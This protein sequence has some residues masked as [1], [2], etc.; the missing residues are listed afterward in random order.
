M[1]QIEYEEIDIVRHGPTLYLHTYL[2]TMNIHIFEH[3]EKGTI[4]PTL[5][6]DTER[7]LKPKSKGRKHANVIL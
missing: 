3:A 2:K 6:E 7:K 1:Q 4:I 5:S